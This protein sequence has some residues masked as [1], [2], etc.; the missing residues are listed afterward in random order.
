MRFRKYLSHQKAFVVIYTSPPYSRKR[1][2]YP[3]S[4]ASAWQL[5]LCLKFKGTSLTMNLRGHA[6][7]VYYVLL[8]FIYSKSDYRF[9]LNATQTTVSHLVAAQ[10]AASGVIGKILKP[11]SIK[12]PFGKRVLV[13][14]PHQDDEAIGCGGALL[15]HRQSGHPVHIVF[16]Q[17]GVSN[18]V[19]DAG[20][21]NRVMQMR[22]N[23]AK[24][25][26]AVGGFEP[27][28]FLRHHTLS[29]D[30]ILTVAESIKTLIDR[31]RPDVIFSPF[32][33]DPDT[34][35]AIT[36]LALALAIKKTNIKCR[37]F[38]YEVWSICIANIGVSINK[39]VEQKKQVLACYESQNSCTDYLHSTIGLNAFHS[40][41]FGDPGSK[42]VEKFFEI[43]SVEFVEPMKKIGSEMWP[44]EAVKILE[45]YK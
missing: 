15:L 35:H 7:K 6:K 28:I 11:L 20:E 9:F 12:A 4:N 38:G 34:D 21:R 31:L 8:R 36:N 40:R 27:P 17:S 5:N 25:A 29:I 30:E 13:L 42:Y 3:D 16:V 1:R 24:V 18:E 10:V 22:E 14:A 23:E 39:V 45:A 19:G 2:Q 32:M 43:S 37:I 41:T 26:A 44:N 33:L